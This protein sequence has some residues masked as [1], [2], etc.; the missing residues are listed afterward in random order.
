M[1]RMRDHI[2]TVV[3][4]YKGQITSWDVVNEALEDQ[5]QLKQS[6]WMRIIGE[7]YIQK[8]F[9]WAH[10]ADPEA[11]LYYNDFN[12]WRPDKRQCVIRM[13]RDLKAKG[14]PV[15]GIGMQGHWGLDYPPLEEL[16]ASIQAYA[17][18]GLKVAITELDMDIL[19]RPSD[20]LGAGVTLNFEYRQE[21]N[22]WPTA[23]P[24]SMQTV[25]AD[26]YREIFQL[27]VKYSDTISRV[28]F[29]G[30]HDGASWRNHWPI[31]GRSAYPLLFDDQRQPK[32]AFDAVIEAVQ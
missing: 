10:E 21:L 4:R 25:L 29:W 19:P 13:I 12:L 6:P 8:A 30:V 18:L 17:D 26:R 24:D 14:V 16:E 27:L 20:D 7:D 5:G 11:E 28:T 22:P 23:L 2:L 15:H 32:T 31:R 9:E 1:Q 3:D